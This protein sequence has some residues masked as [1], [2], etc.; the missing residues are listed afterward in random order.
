MVVAGGF[1]A[2]V[3]PAIGASQSVTGANFAWNP[4]SVGVSPG[5]EVT[6]NWNDGFSHNVVFDDSAAGSG[7]PTPSGTFK[8]TFQAEA[9]VRFR[10]I[11]HSTTFTDGM[12]G[13]VTISSGGG[14]TTE[15][16]TSTTTTTNTTPT[17]TTPTNTTPTTT[18]ADTTAPVMG[19]LRRRSSR[20]ALVITFRSS[21]AA[22]LS[23]AVRRRNPGSRIFRVVAKRIVDVRRGANTVA[24]VRA[25]KRLRRG[26]YRVHLVLEDAAGNVSRQRILSFKLG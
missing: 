11:N 6:W 16:G 1:A 2:A 26:A 7:T 23:A 10:C 5:D 18:P 17:N 24:L 22:E 3:M 4:S 19:S 20:R 25:P 21:E 13:S 9:T 8:R 14:T 12:S 15:T